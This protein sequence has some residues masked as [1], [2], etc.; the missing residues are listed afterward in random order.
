MKK[1]LSIFMGL[2]L[3]AF[4]PSVFAATQSGD[5]VL[6]PGDAAITIVGTIAT[7][8]WEATIVDVTRGGTGIADPT[9]H[10]LIVGSG[11]VAMTELAVGGAGVL[12]LGVA[13]SDPTWTVSTFVEGANDFIITKG[14]AILN[15]DAPLQ[16]TGTGAVITGVD[17]ANTLSMA[18]NLTI[19]GG[20]AVVLASV[21]QENTFT[22]NESLT[23]GD[24]FSGTSTYSGDAKTLTVEDAAIVSQDYSSN[25]SPEFADLTLSGGDLILGAAATAYAGKILLHDADGGDAFSVSIQANADLGA[26]YTLTLPANDGD[27]LQ[28][29]QTNGSG[30]L[31]WAAPTAAPAW[32]TIEGKT[33]SGGGITTGG[34]IFL[35]ITEEGD[36]ADSVTQIDGAA[37]GDVLVIKGVAALNNIITFTDDNSNLDL[38]ADFLMDNQNDTLVLICIATGTPDTFIEVSRASNG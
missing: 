28:Y 5:N 13:A 14:T 34:D 24:G 11:A 10:A 32:G 1:L 9:D 12:L 37:V 15:I 26:N 27:N 25:A 18:E 38:Q 16:V 23:V 22:M 20:T 36:A 8:T 6:I 29:L 31:T 2:M 30:A 7:G 33:V 3:L 35:A 21:T 4:A 17:Q 19:S